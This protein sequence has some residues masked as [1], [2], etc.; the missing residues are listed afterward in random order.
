MNITDYL[1]SLDGWMAYWA[2]EKQ[3]PAVGL[4]VDRLF[5]RGRVE[6]AKLGKVDTYAFVKHVPDNIDGNWARTYSNNLFEYAARIRTGPPLGFGAMLAVYPVLIVN[7]ISTELYN[8]IQNYA[9]KHFAAAEFPSILNLASQDLYYYP[10]TP[11]WGALYYSDYRNQSQ[12]CFSPK[13]WTAI[14]AAAR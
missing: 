3:P 5:Y 7:N 11:V 2:F 14:S 8:W 9:P 13:K 10:K 1:N 6:G 4:D 12:Q